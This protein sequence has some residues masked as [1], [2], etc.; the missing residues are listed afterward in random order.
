MSTPLTKTKPIWLSKQDENDPT[1]NKHYRRSIRYYKKLYR[2]W[3][4]WCANHEGF[5]KI[6]D[7]FKRRK[8][9][10]ETVHKD[11]I[12]P[13][14]SA[15]VCGLHVPWNLQIITEGENLKKSNTWWPDHPYE[16]LDMFPP[17]FSQCNWSC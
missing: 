12:I 10:G 1:L 6:Q 7:E 13:I 11:H 16:T 9:R 15:I 17:L 2:A 4:E 14:C 5:K 8:S 3:P